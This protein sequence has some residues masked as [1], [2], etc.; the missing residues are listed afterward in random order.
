MRRTLLAE[1]GR[2]LQGLHHP[3]EGWG[4]LLRS[5]SVAP[6]TVSAVDLSGRVSIAMLDEAAARRFFLLLGENDTVARAAAAAW[7]AH[8]GT[9]EA[10]ARLAENWVA[11]WRLPGFAACAGRNDKE[12]FERSARARELLALERFERCNVNAATVETLVLLG[13]SNED[14]KQ[15]QAQVLLARAREGSLRKLAARLEENETTWSRLAVTAQVIELRIRAHVPG[16][17]GCQLRAV[18]QLGE[19]AASEA[20]APA[21]A[22]TEAR[23][24]KQRLEAVAQEIRRRRALRGSAASAVNQSANPVGSQ[25][26]QLI[27]TEESFIEPGA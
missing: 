27:E 8:Q 16:L 5:G 24:E 23:T 4:E 12:I 20:G 14:A 1:A 26:Y 17:D 6:V 2:E 25:N 3:D 15:V 11:L 9:V 10:G 22:E 18:L 19:G 7:K 21:T 13:L